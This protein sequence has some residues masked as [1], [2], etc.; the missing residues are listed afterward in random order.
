MESKLVLIVISICMY[1]C[2]F[3]CLLIVGFSLTSR[4]SFTKYRVCFV[5]FSRIRDLLLLFIHSFVVIHF[6]SS[7]LSLAACQHNNGTLCFLIFKIC[8]KDLIQDR[9]N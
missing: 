4:H 6:S 2:S 3:V 8:L 7:F 9:L 1:V 5:L